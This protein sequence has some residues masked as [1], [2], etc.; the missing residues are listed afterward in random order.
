MIAASLAVCNGLVEFDDNGNPT[1]ELFESWEAKP[2]AVEWIFKVRQGVKFSNGK[3]LDADDTLLDRHSPRRRHQVPAKGILGADQGNQGNLAQ[4]SLHHSVRPAMPTSRSFSVTI[5][6]SLSRRTSPTGRSWWAPAHIRSKASS[7]ASA[8]FSKTGVTTGRPAAP[9]LTRS[10]S[11]TFRTLP[12]VQPPC[13]PAKSTPQTVL[14]PARLPDDEGS[15]PNIVRTKGTGNRFCFVMDVTADPY[16]NKDLRL[17]MKYAIDREAIIK[18]VY[19]GYAVP[20]T[21]THSTR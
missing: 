11:A 1:G 16:N 20:V 5:T 10:K 14:M 15:E 17:A 9:T 19:N 4:R 2:G 6:W 7:R 3:A 21:I 8:S 18:Q 12:P 13:S